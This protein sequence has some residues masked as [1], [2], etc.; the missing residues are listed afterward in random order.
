MK[1]VRVKRKKGVIPPRGKKR[2]P[3][4]GR[5]VSGRRIL[6]KRVFCALIPVAVALAV[7]FWITG[8]QTTAVFRAAE[9]GA[10]SYGAD[11]G[12]AFY[13]YR[14]KDFFFCTKDGVQYLS[15]KGEKLW[16]DPLSL[17]APILSAKC[18]VIAVSEVR[19]RAVYVYDANGKLFEQRF[20]DPILT[21]SVNQAGIVTVILQKPADKYSIEAYA[22]GDSPG[23]P[24]DN[25]SDV[26]LDNRP[27]IRNARRIL[28]NEWLRP[29]IYPVS[30]DISPDGRIAAIG[31]LDVNMDAGADMTSNIT[32]LYINQEEARGLIDLA[33]ASEKRPDQMI[34]TVRFMENNKLLTVYDE[35]IE[36]LHPQPDNSIQSAWTIHLRNQIDRLAYAGDQGFAF[37][38]GDSLIGESLIGDSPTGASLPDK[39][40]CLYFYSMTGQK[41]GAYAFGGKAD[42]LSL[43]WNS[44]LVGSGGDYY[45]VSGRGRLLWKYAARDARQIIFVG[46]SRSILLGDDH[47]AAVMRLGG[48]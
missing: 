34:N 27:G 22:P 3:V 35:T 2:T 9:D 31:F 20:D 29:N 42:S 19:G 41:T 38:T 1:K 26:R 21:F 36:C 7:F 23:D 6:W 10:V 13:S 30:A 25:R 4:L 8:H 47:S 37:T 45:A 18:G 14:S 12:A 40:G 32:F 24:S 44:A 28:Y 17:T 43:D 39:S 46:N 15:A 48:K 16:D 5:R 33:F 11:S